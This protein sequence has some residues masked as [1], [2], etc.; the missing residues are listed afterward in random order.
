MTSLISLQRNEID[1]LDSLMPLVF[2]MNRDPD[3]FLSVKSILS[4][5]VHPR[6]DIITG[7]RIFYQL[8]LDLSK[9]MITH[10]RVIYSILDVMCDIGGVS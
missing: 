10:S 9:Q 7:N 6:H 1:T 2:R 4:D 3:G 8:E 5:I